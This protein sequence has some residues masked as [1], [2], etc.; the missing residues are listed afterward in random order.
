MVG[1]AISLS[2]KCSG[3]G[4]QMGIHHLKRTP[5]AVGR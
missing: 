1:T 4:R 5:S 2:V 3:A